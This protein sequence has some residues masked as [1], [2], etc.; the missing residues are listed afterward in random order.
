VPLR[1]TRATGIL[2]PI[3]PPNVDIGGNG[4]TGGINVGPVHIGGKPQVTVSGGSKEVR[5]WAAL[6]VEA[7]KSVTPNIPPEILLGLIEVE[8]SGN[9]NAISS[10]RAFGLTQFIPATAAT[11]GVKPG[12]A[13]SQ[14]YG[15]AHYLHDL[16]YKKGNEARAVGMYNPLNGKPNVG[17]SSSVLGAARKYK[18][19]GSNSVI[20]GGVQVDN[21]ATNQAAGLLD[22]FKDG[23]DAVKTVVGVIINPSLLGRLVARTYAFLLKLVWKAIWE[24]VIAP[25]WH[26]IQRAVDYY[27]NQIMSGKVQSG[28]YYNMAGIVTIA[29]WSMGYAILFGRAEDPGL[30]VD[31]RDSML[32][33][34]VR[35]GQNVFASRNI[36]K[37]S[38]VDESTKNKPEPSTSEIPVSEQR[39]ISVT[40]RRPVKVT[41]ADKS[42]DQTGDGNGDDATT[43]AGE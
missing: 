32:G 33:R 6:C 43:T 37:P 14:I 5:Q 22:G 15:A 25:I 12:D 38:K 16:G 42:T 27:F 21:S 18:V 29:F 23:W 31:A 1:S 20:S 8:S 9:I 4:H 30:A 3:V 7:G 19:E 40:R 13:R 34:S 41:R 24:V 11:Y 36:V 35:T 10:A 2:A 28:Y 17:Y 26:W 39:R